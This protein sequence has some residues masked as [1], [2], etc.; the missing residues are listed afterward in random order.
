MLNFTA[1]QI[2]FQEVPDE[3]SLAFTISGCP[4]GCKGCHSADSW[5][6]NSGLALGQEYFCQRLQD[7]RGLIRL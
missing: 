6:E 4:L 5:S 2:V 7:Y 3:V 1:E